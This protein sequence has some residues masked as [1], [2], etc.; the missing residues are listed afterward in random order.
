MTAREVAELLGVS[1]ETVLR[2][3]RAG[4]LPA[5][6][7]P[8]GALRFREDAIDAWLEERATSSRGVVTHPAE[9]RPAGKVAVSPTREVEED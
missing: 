8:G 7:L 4:T 5:F 6:R 2:Y 1:S 9:R 3:V